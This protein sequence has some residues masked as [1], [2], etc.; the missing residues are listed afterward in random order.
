MTLKVAKAL[1]F[2]E[3]EAKQVVDAWKQH[4]D[5][6]KCIASVK[7][8]VSDPKT[9]CGLLRV[10]A[11]EAGKV[12][13]KVAAQK[14]V[15]KTAEYKKFAKLTANEQA[16]LTEYFKKLYGEDYVKALVGDY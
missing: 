2:R 8:K 6:N 7:G 16:F 14:P 13:T 1:D 11:V 15:A 12:M 9:Y 4:G 10:A 5:A 3:W